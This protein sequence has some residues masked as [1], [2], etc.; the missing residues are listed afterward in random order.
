M[1]DRKSR[2]AKLAP[3]N[4]RES[5]DLALSAI[6]FF[7]PLSYR[8]NCK[9]LGITLE[10]GRIEPF[11]GYD[12]IRYLEITEKLPG[13]DRY[14]YLIR[15]LLSDLER[16]QLLTFYGLGKN[17]TSGPAYYCMREFTNIEKKGFLWL[18][19]ALGPE[20]VLFAYSDITVQITGVTPAGDV[21][22]GTGIIISPTHILT[23]AHVA[24]GMKI[25]HCQRASNTTYNVAGI[26]SHESKD[27]AIIR[28]DNE[29]PILPGMG[30]RDPLISEGVY[31]LGYPRI[32]LSTEPS[33]V[34]Q[35]GEVTNPE[36]TMFSGD[37]VFLYSAV[38]RPG[39]SGGPI[40]SESGHVVGIVTESLEENTT[41][42][43]MPFHAGIKTAELTSA[44]AELDA[45]IELPIET[46]E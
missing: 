24:N 30:F 33:L 11:D 35:R 43:G 46:Y 25:D 9:V 28:S 8:E 21:H 29:L 5:L 27:V 14:I 4:F 1:S 44:V 6:K 45:N 42:S 16:A 10:K 26:I 7:Q 18:A 2:Y 13:A 41:Q 19:P 3:L 22:A 31:T 40:I 20:L 39:N 38:A 36:V 12:F 34:M 15:K 23:C 32:P 37:K 17:P